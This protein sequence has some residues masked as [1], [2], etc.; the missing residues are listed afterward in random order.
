MNSPC[1]ECIVNM[2]CKNP[3]ADLPE[4]IRSIS[5]DLLSDWYSV[6]VATY[7]RYG[8]VEIIGDRIILKS[9]GCTI[10]K[11]YTNEVNDI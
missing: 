1:E 11:L 5:T 4:F 6:H 2:M 10:L 3:C 7:L 9:S 8:V